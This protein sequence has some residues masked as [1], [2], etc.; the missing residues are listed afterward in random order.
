MAG[1]K[2]IT[3]VLDSC[4]TTKPLNKVI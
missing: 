1:L 4:I 2:K 3:E